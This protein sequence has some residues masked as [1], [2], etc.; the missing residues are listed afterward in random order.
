MNVPMAAGRT[1]ALSRSAL[2]QTT[3]ATAVSLKVTVES[4]A[5]A[6]SIG[7]GACGGVPWIVAFPDAPAQSY[8]LVVPNGA[9]SVCVTS[10]VDAVVSLTVT[11]QWVR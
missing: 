9:A 4:P 3:N 5:S 11:G 7:I 6:G 2:G 8:T 10:T 1:V